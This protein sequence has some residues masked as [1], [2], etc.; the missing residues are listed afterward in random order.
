M[1]Q[2]PTRAQKI[3]AGM[4]WIASLTF[5]FYIGC[6]ANSAY[7]IHPGS[8][9]IGSDGGSFDSHTADFLSDERKFLDSYKGKTEPA[10]VQ[11]FL[12][13]AEK[14]YAITKASYLNWRNVQTAVALADL[15]NQK[16]ELTTA[17]GNVAA[18]QK[19]SGQ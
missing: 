2:S 11:S 3:V 14:Q 19:T 16:T 1:N 8:I 13:V 18:A 12:N 10:A 5:V 6:A 15:N 7:I 9:A 17:V 4:L